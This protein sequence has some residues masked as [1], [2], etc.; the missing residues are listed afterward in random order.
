M[1]ER[2]EVLFDDCFGSTS[3]ERISERINAWLK[4]QN[5]NMEITRVVGIPLG[6]GSHL[7]ILIFYQPA[8]EQ[9]RTKTEPPQPITLPDRKIKPSREPMPEDLGDFAA[10]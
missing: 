5:E 8:K 9:T 1:K 7:V 4:G 3:A 10:L 2:V 6:T